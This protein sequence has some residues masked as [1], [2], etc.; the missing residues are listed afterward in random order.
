MKKMNRILIIEDEDM[1]AKT[2]KKALE[3]NG[4]A[5]EIAEDGQRGIQMIKEK[6]YD[7][8][9]LDLKMPKVSGENVL[10][11]IREVQPYVF[12]IVYT[13]FREFTDIKALVNIGI[14]GY[15]NKGADADLQSLVDMIKE[16]LQPFSMEQAQK[17][18]ET[19]DIGREG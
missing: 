10:R 17:I 19:A 16:K 12:V 15:V 2:V 14:D 11:V 9:L 6:D 4:M 18:I 13:N 8:I 1:T 5:A 3:L 7:L